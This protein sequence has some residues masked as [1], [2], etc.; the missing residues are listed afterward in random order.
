MDYTPYS[1]GLIMYHF[2]AVQE[3]K[4]TV[5]SC[6]FGCTILKIMNTYKDGYVFI[7]FKISFQGYSIFFSYQRTMLYLCFTVVEARRSRHLCM[8]QVCER[9]KKKQ[10]WWM[11]IIF[12]IL[13][14]MI[15]NVL[16]AVIW[17]RE[18][19]TEMYI[20]KQSN[21]LLKDETSVI[22]QDGCRH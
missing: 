14:R 22:I 10:T 4:C 7:G 8:L 5:V 6:N 13:Q 3:H 19:Q 17:K 1:C 9:L 18:T 12:L 20:L 11:H 16:T 21:L 2:S 15:V